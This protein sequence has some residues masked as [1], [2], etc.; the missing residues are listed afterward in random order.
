MGKNADVRLLEAS[1]NF[2]LQTPPPLL[3][4]PSPLLAPPLGFTKPRLPP[5]SKMA[6]I[7]G[8]GLSMAVWIFLW[9]FGFF[10]LFHKLNF[11]VCN[12]ERATLPF[13]VEFCFV[14]FFLE[15]CPKLVPVSFV[16]TKWRTFWF[17]ISNNWK[18]ISCCDTRLDRFLFIVATSSNFKGN[19]VKLL[20]RFNVNLMTFYHRF[21]LPGPYATFHT[22]LKGHVWKFC[23]F[24]VRVNR[25]RVFQ[26]VKINWME[27]LVNFEPIWSILV[28]TGQ[29]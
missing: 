7:D 11:G 6:D 2:P 21:H 12:S 13:E 3:A 9:H 14:L 20:Q 8:R 4:P 24:D 23:H 25:F 27:N 19:D 5:K 28:K 10:F 17:L 15:T 22:K 29:N 1:R 16:K 18:Y 26:F